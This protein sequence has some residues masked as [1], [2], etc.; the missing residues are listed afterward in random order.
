M[1]ALPSES[2][3]LDRQRALQIEAEQVVRDVMLMEL[4]SRRQ[5]RAR[6]D[7]LARS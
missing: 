4:G 1:N 2:E 3:L 5:R 7:G 6:S